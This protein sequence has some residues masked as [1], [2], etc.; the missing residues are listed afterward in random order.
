LEAGYDADPP[1]RRY[2]ARRR[3]R[4]LRRY[5][6]SGRLLEVGSAAGYFL[7]AAKGAGFAVTGIEPAEELARAA[8]IRFGV[9][10]IAGFVEDA[11][12]EPASAG[13]VC[14]WHV[15][16]HIP[17]PLAVLGELRTVLA[18]GGILALEVPNAG[19]VEA[20]RLGEAWPHW[21]PAHH[22]G[23]YTPL[24]LRTLVGRAGYE[25]VHVETLSG[26]AYYPPRR[27]L[28]PMVL[29]ES[30]MLGVRLRSVPWRPHATRHE[31]LRLVARA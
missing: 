14:A 11:D 7:D 25:V 27:A 13:T 22:V 20:G 31:L 17:D 4:F 30:A 5:V 26:V 29:A 8:R 15:L 12:L 24:A 23:H 3:V 1:A 2:E 18:P 6:R 9:D 28:R 16:E 10:V 19:S 21:D